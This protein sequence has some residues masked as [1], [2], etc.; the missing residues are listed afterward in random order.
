[1]CLGRRRLHA[2]QCQPGRAWKQTW[3]EVF[4]ASSGYLQFSQGKNVSQTRKR[5]ADHR[6]ELKVKTTS[7]NPDKKIWSNTAAR[8]AES[9]AP[10]TL[11]LQSRFKLFTVRKRPHAKGL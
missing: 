6:E 11:A 5:W 1:M 4:G 8:E 7:P 3:I 10:Q 9:R 2:P